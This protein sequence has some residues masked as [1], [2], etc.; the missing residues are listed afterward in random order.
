[1]A[2]VQSTNIIPLAFENKLVRAV[3]HR[4]QP[5]F[6]G[7]DVCEVLELKNSRQALD[8]LDGDE[9]GVHT[10]DTLGGEQ[11]MVIVNEPG[12]FRLVFTSRKPEAE[13]FKRWLA[14]E[15]LPRLRQDGS[16][17][18]PGARDPG[19]L[20]EEPLAALNVKLALL[21]EARHLFGPERARRMW[22]QLGLPSVPIDT[23]SPDADARACLDLLV[24]AEVPGTDLSVCGLLMDA[25]EGHAEAD[26]MLQAVGLRALAD[27]AD[28]GDDA[29]WIANGGAWLTRLYAGTP[30]A[31]GR[32]R[33]AL[34]RLAGVKGG[35][36]FR[37]GGVTRRGTYVPATL[38]DRAASSEK[39]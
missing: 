29:L 19:A 12:V 17:A 21:R 9:K 20:P 15:V 33:F 37:S 24:H 31:L 10:V 4:G 3:H 14:H 2:Q 36:M 6:V 16:Y 28:L 34:R 27:N 30:W 5:W 1:M 26:L 32:W 7:R 13:R 35:G 38:V 11:E 39:A 18:L 8:R 25:L 22:P 23:A